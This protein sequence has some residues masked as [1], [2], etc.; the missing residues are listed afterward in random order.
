MDF[1]IISEITNIET[2]ARGFGVR[3]R[4]YLNRQYAG[5]RKM[6][7]RHCKGI[8]TIRYVNGEVW[9]AEV[10]WFEAYGIGRRGEFV[11]HRI[12]RLG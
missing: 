6:R 3:I 8:A 7:W 11:K 4:A 9:L 1:E 5:G 12:R 10:H 2:F